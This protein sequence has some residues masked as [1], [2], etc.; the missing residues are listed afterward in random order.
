M[1]KIRVVIDRA[2]WRTGDIG[3][4]K[5]GAGGTYLKNSEGYKCCLGFICEAVKPE[6]DFLLVAQ[7]GDLTSPVEG[8]NMLECAEN[9]RYWNTQ[10]SLKAM[11]INDDGSLL[12]FERELKLQELFKDS[13]YELEF[14]N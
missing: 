11:N 13:P 3:P 2:K 4:N 14:V 1:S 5:T 10:L 12:L 6:L 8:L 9:D 7:P